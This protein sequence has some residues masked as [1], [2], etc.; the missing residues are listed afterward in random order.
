V[1]GLI[2]DRLK[3]WTRNPYLALCALAMVLATFFVVLALH[4]RGAAAITACIY[5]AQFFLWFYNGPI[6][7]V[8]VNTVSASLR[9]RAFSLSILCIH[10]FGDA[11]SPSAVGFLSD[12]GGLPSALTLIPLSMGL[13]ALVWGVAWRALPQREAPVAHLT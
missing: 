9:V 6:N 8:L 11:I 10:L 13:G 3:R 2:A 12:R 1:G 4:V 7:A 5:A